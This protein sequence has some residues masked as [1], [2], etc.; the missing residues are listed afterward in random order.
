MEFR[1]LDVEYPEDP[2]MS[3]ALEEAMFHEVRKGNSPPTFRF[4]RHRNAV[5]IG[6]FQLSDQEIDSDVVDEKK[7]KIVKRF[8]G[9]G[10]VY[11]DMGNLNY[12]IITKDTFGINLNVTKLYSTMIDGALGAF[13]SL[14]INAE[15]GK[16]NDVTVNNKKILGAAATI[17]EHTLLY[18][19]CILVDVDLV[20]LASVLKVPGE[21]LKDKGV[22]TILERVTNIKDVS[23]NT[24]DDVKR[25][26]MDAY[27]E[28]LGITFKEGKP[29]DAELKLAKELYEKKYSLK[30]WNL[31]A[32]VINIV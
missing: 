11:H 21:K 24:V 12:S 14:G 3:L 10:A 30:D 5:I 9:G 17:R 25:A 4:Y 23:G 32:A 15:S 29:T 31:G 28:T 18:H 1:F 22:K 27:S 7:I 19:A 13:K 6:C 8:T 2:H 26:L 16:L 20:T